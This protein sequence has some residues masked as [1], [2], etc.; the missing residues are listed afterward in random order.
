MASASSPGV[1]VEPNTRIV[2]MY[3]DQIAPKDMSRDMAARHGFPIYPTVAEAL[4][5]H[6]LDL[7]RLP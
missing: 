5:L 1:R 2:S 4:S 6:P 3:T 7:L